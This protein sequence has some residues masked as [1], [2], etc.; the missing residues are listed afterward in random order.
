M[1]LGDKSAKYMWPE[2]KFEPLLKI[3]SNVL[4]P[5]GIHHAISIA[6]SVK[7]DKSELFDIGSETRLEG[8]SGNFFNFRFSYR[9]ESY[10][11]S[12]SSE[13][14][15]PAGYLTDDTQS[16]QVAP[17]SIKSSTE[18][19]PLGRG[20]R[21]KVRKFYSDELGGADAAHLKSAVRNRK[22]N[23]SES[24]LVP[25]LMPGQEVSYP[26]MFNEDPRD[27]SSSLELEVRLATPVASSSNDSRRRQV[28]PVPK[29]LTIPVTR[30]ER[31]QE[32]KEEEYAIDEM[33]LQRLLNKKAKLNH[34]REQLEAL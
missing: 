31:I 25:T 19:E 10:L 1:T 2:R 29:F 14:L 27:R 17:E 23:R 16:L 8:L 28:P 18:P 26:L 21:R 15:N 30:A 11:Q 6:K 3:A 33:I 5:D 12:Q 7:V 24:D 9:S 32:L 4:V 20:H 13:R 34:E 22:H